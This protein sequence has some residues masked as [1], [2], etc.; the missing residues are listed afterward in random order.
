[1]ILLLKLFNKNPVTLC[2]VFVYSCMNY[3]SQFILRKSLNFNLNFIEVHELFIC[4][5]LKRNFEVLPKVDSPF[6]TLMRM[7]I[8]I[9]TAS[10]KLKLIQR[11]LLAINYILYF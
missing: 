8:C 10:L 7:L 5:N 9:A 3:A 11:N 6:L 1:M 4:D 2:R